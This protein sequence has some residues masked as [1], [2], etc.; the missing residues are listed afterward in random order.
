MKTKS[1]IQDSNLNNTDMSVK[2][3]WNYCQDNNHWYLTGSKGPEVWERLNITDRIYPGQLVLNIGVGLGYCTHELVK[4]KCFV[5]ALDISE[6]ALD[7]VRNVV[8]RAWLPNQL[9]ELPAATFDLVISHLVTQHMNNGDLSDQLCAVIKSLKPDGIFAM[10]FTY[11]LNGKYDL[12]KPIVPNMKAGGVCRSLIKM[13]S[14]V[15]NAH[16]KILW[17]DKIDFFPEWNAGWYGIHI[18]KQDENNS[19]LRNCSPEN[20]RNN[21]RLFNE[22]GK[23]MFNA[24]EGDIDGAKMAF[25]HCLELD[26]EFADAH[27]NLGVMYCQQANHKRALEHFKKAVSLEPKNSLFV[28]NYAKLC[29][30]IGMI[31]KAENL[32]SNFSGVH[33]KSKN[34]VLNIRKEYL[35]FGK[36][37]FSDEEIKAVSRTMRTGWVGMGQETIK[38]EDELSS[39]LDVPH[40]VTVNSCTSALFL[41]LLIHGIGPGDEVICPSLS[42]CSTAN[43]AL[44]LGAKPVFCDV[45]PDT[46]CI[47][48]KSVSEKLTERTRAVI[49]VHFG[50]LAADVEQIHSILPP[51]A[52]IVEDAAH[53]LGTKFPNTKAVGTSGNLTCFSFYANKNLSTAEGGAIALFDDEQAEHIRS[54]RQHAIASNA[55]N[56]FVQPNSI[57]YSVLAE[58]GYKMNYTDLQ[59]AI[60][61]VQ[62]KR[63]SEFQA[64]RLEIANLYYQEL[65][66]LKPYIRFQYNVTHPYHARHLF[67]V[68]LPVD[69]MTITRDEFLLK[70]RSMNIGAS[71][72]YAPLH[73][74]P[75]YE[76]ADSSGLVHTER[77]GESIL[78]LP[79]SASMSLDDARYVSGKFVDLFVQSIKDRSQLYETS[80]LCERL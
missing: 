63:Q 67:T 34:S 46:L 68:V 78:T 37:D 73:T 35:P 59:A 51:D 69:K 21:A 24:G 20:I 28:D 44:Y 2:E 10:Q 5:H 71:V 74:M 76:F 39:Y 30:S 22:D 32:Y 52:A 15:E 12:F 38:F 4:R 31:D 23:A 17:V 56:R 19:L 18:V 25:M 6:V 49:I 62:L 29:E 1:S 45:D 70:L 60:G 75:L 65:S 36:P 42:W 55:W 16:G 77:I 40:V 54:L 80:G 57:V 50:G 79:I 11:S 61:R 14:L 47:T 8:A 7:K 53:A 43:A 41:S 66:F 3:W 72:H 64:R 48:P 9:G 27:N 13:N 26:P 33:N 58:L